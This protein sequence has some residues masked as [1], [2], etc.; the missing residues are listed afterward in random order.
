MTWKEFKEAAENQGIKDEMQ[1]D[2]IDWDGY[3]EPNVNI[4]LKDNFITIT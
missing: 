1:V 4:N 2:Y 3:E